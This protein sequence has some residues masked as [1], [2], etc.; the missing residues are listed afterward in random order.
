MSVRSAFAWS[1][2]GQIASFAATFG[3]TV[4][5]ARLLSPRE[6]GIYAAGLAVVGILQAISAFGVGSYVIRENELTPTTLSTAFTINAAL[7]LVLA[8]LV[9]TASFSNWITA[10]EPEVRSVLQLL[11]VVPLLN[12]FELRPATMLQRQMNFQIISIVTTGRALAGAVVTIVAAWFGAGALSAAYGGIVQALVGAMGFSL[13]ARSHVGVSISTV[14]WRTMVRFGLQTLAIGGVSSA[15]ARASEFILGRM[16]GFSALGLYSRASALSNTLFQNFYGSMARV[17]FSRLAE[18]HRS[19]AGTAR[20][21]LNGLDIV[22]AIMWPLLAGLSVLAGP[23]VQIL[24][25]S[26]WLAA[27]LPLSI[28]LIAQAISLSFAMNHELFVLRDRLGQQSWLETVRSIVGIAA[29]A[30]GCYYGITGA[31]AARLLDAIVGVAL[32]VPLLPML[33]GVRRRALLIVYLR[34]IALAVV[35][36]G[37]AVGIMRYMAWNP[38]TSPFLIAMAVTVGIALWILL[39]SYLRHPLFVEL[40]RLIIQVRHRFATAPST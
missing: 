28:L 18:D 25:G 4:L 36:I 10:G 31:A 39:L 11:S 23:V 20:S 24:F 15:S 3:T 6:I 29:F 22:L 12:A 19:N 32:Y 34:G 33:S 27:A 8:G 5:L 37:P 26:K 38:A 1:I 17:L 16:L 9:F 7:C 13:L 40:A 21:Y 30:V 2:A 14:G 35:A